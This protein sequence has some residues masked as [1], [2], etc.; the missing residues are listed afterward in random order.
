ML[1]RKE[2]IEN[3]KKELVEKINKCITLIPQKFVTIGSSFNEVNIASK[4]P[5][6]NEIDADIDIAKAF[7]DMQI[8]SLKKFFENGK[9]IF[10]NNF[11]NDYLKFSDAW[12]EFLSLREYLKCRKYLKSFYKSIEEFFN[13]NSNI[14]SNFAVLA[15]ENEWIKKTEDNIKIILNTFVTERNKHDAEKNLIIKFFKSVSNFYY[16]LQETKEEV[17]SKIKY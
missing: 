6:T 8:Y 10:L 15:K 4:I 11:S 3:L 9:K 16:F 14:L 7:I 2:Y 5:V 13:K 12:I 1:K 17:I